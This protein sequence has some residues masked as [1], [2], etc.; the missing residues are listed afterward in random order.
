MLGRALTAYLLYV[1]WLEQG[2]MEP[3]CRADNPRQR[4]ALWFA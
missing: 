4:R 3:L 2:V 1:E